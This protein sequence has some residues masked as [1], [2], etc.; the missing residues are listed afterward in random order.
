M[1][2]GNWPPT[3][4]PAISL[5]RWP[6]PRFQLWGVA[7]PASPEK[8]SKPLRFKPLRLRTHPNL[9]QIVPQL[10]YILHLDR[11]HPHLRRKLQI[12]S[13]VVDENA[14]LR[15]ELSCLQSQAVNATVGLP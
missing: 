12:L 9:F 5:S 8:I 1:E 13:S 2:I 11:V 15:I 7:S 3:A 10:F 6:N 14:L 4:G